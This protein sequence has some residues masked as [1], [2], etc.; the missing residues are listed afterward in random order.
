MTT[1]TTEKVDASI[2]DEVIDA[3]KKAVS[4]A[5]S[6]Y[7]KAEKAFVAA[8][9]DDDVDFKALMALSDA[10]KSAE[11]GV[12]KADKAA[13]DAEFERGASERG[14]IVD[15]VR[16][17]LSAIVTP[18]IEDLQR[19]KIRGFTIAL[20]EDGGIEVSATVPSAPKR[21]GGGGGR[22]RNKWT[23][24]GVEHTS[25][26]FLQGPGLEAKGQDW[27]DNVLERAAAG[28]GFDAPVKALAKELGAVGTKP[29]G[30]DIPL[31]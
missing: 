6:A 22:G 15:S 3:L 28:A 10:V 29:D 2:T 9:A 30:S 1:E 11:R 20:T 21:A 31:G 27:V 23:L 19:T 4:T 13:T 16:E 5:K 14:A 7:T 8:R 18:M 26:E 17:A 24:N 12:S 25:K